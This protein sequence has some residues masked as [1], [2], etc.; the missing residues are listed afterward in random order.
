M[1]KSKLKVVDENDGCFWMSI[2][3]FAK[4][5]EGIGNCKVRYNYVYN[6]IKLDFVE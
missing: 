3:D 1:L 6:S 4:Y 5:F 2:E